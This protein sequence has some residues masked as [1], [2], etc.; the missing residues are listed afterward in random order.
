MTAVNNFLASISSIIWARTNPGLDAVTKQSVVN[1][2]HGDIGMIPFGNKKV[3]R[4]LQQADPDCKNAIQ[5]LISG[6]VPTKK[7]RGKIL[8]RILMEC[9]VNKTGFLIKKEYDAK[10]LKEVKKVVVPQTYLHSVLTI[11]HSK[12]M[13]PTSHQ[14]SQVFKKYFYAPNSTKAVEEI[15]SKCDTCISFSRL[16]NLIP[17]EPSRMPKHP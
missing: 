11:L 6:N 1:S 5:L 2:L 13:H 4:S 7:S 10:A 9:T 14:L 16:T 8:H 3:W 12:P 15:K 17:I